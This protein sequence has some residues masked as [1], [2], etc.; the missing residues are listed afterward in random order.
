MTSD[1]KE[2]FLR[3]NREQN[4][5]KSLDLTRSS[6]ALR[7]KFRHTQTEDDEEVITD[8]KMRIANAIEETVEVE[9]QEVV[10]VVVDDGK[11]SFDVG[12]KKI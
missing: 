4:L 3:S 2:L 1:A 10:A 5:W 7:I 8:E 12:G 11:V 6:Y 9:Q